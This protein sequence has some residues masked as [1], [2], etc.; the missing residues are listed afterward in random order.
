MK[1]I[2]FYKEQPGILT[3]ELLEFFIARIRWGRP[4]DWL[5]FNVDKDLYKEIVLLALRTVSN[6]GTG[7]RGIN[8]TLFIIELG[9]YWHKWSKEDEDEEEQ[10]YT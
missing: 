6:N 10:N 5:F 3:V 4:G 9:L 2:T 7:F 8:I 1:I